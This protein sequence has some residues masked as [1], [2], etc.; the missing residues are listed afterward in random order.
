ML[1]FKRY[2]NEVIRIGDDIRIIITEIRKSVVKVAIE[3]P[4]DVLIIREEL[5]AN[6]IHESG[7]QQRSRKTSG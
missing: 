6:D 4:A 3:A 7:H 1:V 5:Y 2:K